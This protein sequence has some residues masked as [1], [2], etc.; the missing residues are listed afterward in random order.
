[1]AAAAAMGGRMDLAR[2]YRTRALELQ[3][4]FSVA[5]WASRMPQRDP[6]D[7][8]FYVEA[9]RQAGFK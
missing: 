7:V 5:R 9:L 1:M 4:D 6:A 3:P 2:R 8:D